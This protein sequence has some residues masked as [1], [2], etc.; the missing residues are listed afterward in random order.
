MMVKLRYM[1]SYIGIMLAAE[2][3]AQTVPPTRWSHT[4]SAGQVKTG[5]YIDL[6]FE[7]ALNETYYI[8]S[9]DFDGDVGPPP[10]EINFEAH[11]SY[12]LV[13]KLTPL[14]AT[15]KYDEVLNAT[16]R[17]MAKEAVFRQK[18]RILNE[19]PVIKGNYT[20][21][22]CSITD[23]KCIPGDGVFEFTGLTVLPKEK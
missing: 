17:Y 12:R 3:V 9:N 4:F 14:N 19:H 11:K 21:L 8:Y 23:G 20:Y 5:D 15:E 18:V 7:V 1:I 13:G 16:Y 6:I 22:V 2:G 10:T